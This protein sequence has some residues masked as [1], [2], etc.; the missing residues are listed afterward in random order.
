L[1]TVSSEE[2][3]DKIMAANTSQTA[4][5][6]IPEQRDPQTYAIIGAAMEVHTQLGNGFLE[7]IY[8]EALAMEFALRNIPFTREVGLSV[9]Y[10]DNPLACKYQADFICYGEIIV[11]LKAIS[12]LSGVDDA[13]VINYLK[14]TGLKRGLLL[15]FGASSLQHKRLV[16]DY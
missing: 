1:S 9:S 7:A 4:V 2:H 6:T 8:Q 5:R 15:N 14:A 3:L 16:F 11:E 10:K 12:A 13:Q